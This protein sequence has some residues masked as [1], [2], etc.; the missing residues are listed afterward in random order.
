MMHPARTLLATVKNRI[1]RL[2]KKYWAW[3]YF[4][5]TRVT[6]HG[7]I[8]VLAPERIAFGENCFINE[9]VLIDPGRGL[10]IG[11]NV[12]ISPGVMIL[13]SDLDYGRD[14]MDHV[15]GKIVIEDDVWIGAGSIILKNTTIGQGSVIGAGSVVTRDIPPNVVAAG[16]PARVIKKAKA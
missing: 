14:I 4:R 6:V 2:R 3:S 5:N 13:G 10:H 11:N 7:K 1:K 8:K 16:N 15:A 12:V 9:N